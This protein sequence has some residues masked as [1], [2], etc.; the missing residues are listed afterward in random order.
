VTISPDLNPIKHAWNRLK[1]I[2]F[3][4]DPALATYTEDQDELY[5]YY[6]NIINTAWA[7]ISQEYFNR[8]I[9][10][11]PRRVKARIAARG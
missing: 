1:E 7:K 10:L 2:I 5:K 3:D 8:L 6:L 11:I 4:I 9:E